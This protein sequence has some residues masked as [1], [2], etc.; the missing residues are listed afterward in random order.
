MNWIVAVN[1]V[2]NSTLTVAFGAFL[3]FLFG[4]ENSLMHKMGKCN[5]LFVKAVLSVCASGALYNALTISAPPLPEVVT[6]IALALLF[7][8]TSWFHYKMYV[9]PWRAE[10]AKKAVK[11]ARKTKK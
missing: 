10:T 5:T 2:A 8:W 9:K 4:R 1:L 3:M 7:A 6:N 11:K